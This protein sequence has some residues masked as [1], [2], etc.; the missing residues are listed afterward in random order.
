MWLYLDTY[1]ENRE[2]AHNPIASPCRAQSVDG[3]P[4]TLIQTGEYDF[5]R[6]EGEAFAHKL[7]DHGV[8]VLLSRCHRLNHDF[9][10]WWR[11]LKEV[12]AR[13]DEACDWLKVTLACN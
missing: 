10:R 4:P 8:P 9:W 1:L 7:Q 6:D 12:D 3:L 11:V 2:D 13:V 5:L